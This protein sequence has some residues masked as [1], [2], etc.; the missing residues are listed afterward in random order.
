MTFIISEHIYIYDLHIRDCVICLY[1]VIQ[2]YPGAV[3]HPWV[4][5][6][7]NIILFAHSNIFTDSSAIV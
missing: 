7:L 2:C 3:F 1:W 6:I 5:V 4:Y